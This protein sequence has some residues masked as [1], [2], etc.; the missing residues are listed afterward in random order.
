L[1]YILCVS[2]ELWIIIFLQRNVDILILNVHYRIVTLS[3]CRHRIIALSPSQCRNVITALSYCHHRT[4]VLSPSG[5]KSIST[6]ALMVFRRF[7]G[8]FFPAQIKTV[9]AHTVHSQISF[10][11]SHLLNNYVWTILFIFQSLDD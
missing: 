6:M 3:H 7:P 9:K 10:C 8:V 4:I 5:L 2:L 1:L 11:A